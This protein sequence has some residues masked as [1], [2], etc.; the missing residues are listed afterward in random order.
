MSR[1]LLFNTDLEI[2]GTPTVVRELA[3][4]LP[5]C[6]VDI[7]VACLGRFGPTA[8]QIAGDG[9]TVHALNARVRQLPSAVQRLRNLVKLE[10]FDTVLSFLV[11]ANTVAALAR[12]KDDGVH[13]WQSIQ[14]TQPTPRWHW[15]VQ[16]WAGRRAE[17][18]IVPSQSIRAVAR[19][20]SGIEPARVHVLPN[21]VDAADVVEQARPPRDP[22]SVLRVGFLGRLD[23]VK[24]VPLLVEAMRDLD[25]VELHVFG[26]GPD[27]KNIAGPHVHLHG[28]TDRHAALD[29]IDALCL[30]SIAEGFPMV[31][32]EA[33][34]AGLPVVGTDAP[35]IRDA[36]VDGETGLLFGSDGAGPIASALRRV[37]DH[38]TEAATRAAH[39]LYRV[40]VLWTWQ[41]IVPFYAKLLAA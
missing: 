12:R 37:R 26:D 23:P 5:A 40:R 38:P 17:G 9:G 6:G 32:I 24:R 21:G 16:R 13:W 14:T 1:V 29:Q 18:F 2:G 35:G 10:K 7:E 39:A 20:R 41:S 25:R 33:M 4:R 34:A 8:E 11:H 15:R 36:I 30:P 22:T 27:R 3:R 31:I 19:Q 28:F